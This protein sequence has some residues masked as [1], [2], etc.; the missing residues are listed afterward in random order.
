MRRDGLVD[1]FVHRKVGIHDQTLHLLAIRIAE[2]L[3]KKAAPGGTAGEP[4]NLYA[5]Q[6]GVALFFSM[7]YRVSGEDFFRRLALSLLE[8]YRARLLQRDGAE[9]LVRE[10]GLGAAAGLGAALYMLE[11][12]A[13]LC[14]EA[15]LMADAGRLVER[16]TPAL[17]EL[18]A[19][20]DLL[21]GSG[22][23][24]LPLLSLHD[25]MQTEEPL[26]K[27]V[28]AG[29]FL[30][31]RRTAAENGLR[32]WR[33][34]R[35]SVMDGKLLTGFS[36][37]AAG[38]A[39]ALFKLYERSGDE[40]FLAA[41]MEAVLYEQSQFSR[42]AGNWPDYR[43]TGEAVFQYANNWCHGAPGIVLARIGGLAVADNPAIREEIEI[44]LKTLTADEQ[45]ATYD[46]LCC[47][48]AGRLD[49]LMAAAQKLRRPHLYGRARRRLEKML[50]RS[51]ERGKFLLPPAESRY[52]I[53]LFCGMAGIGY[54]LLR[55]LYPDKV[56]CV[57]LFE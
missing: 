22:G 53:G 17:L 28:M 42:E 44:G 35:I 57:L 2:R 51:V 54:V 25:G 46:H 49:V 13:R 5:G 39:Y 9:R 12:V 29:R 23:L 8:P 18:D 11:K 20:F 41:G 7:Y 34:R 26:A 55:F 14:G 50:W 1:G 27:A 47:G 45:E 24:I 4:G 19:D 48:E 33:G 36:H 6:G 15:E 52:K 16:L 43:Q 21:Y 32:A 38:I 31:E 37:G 3:A 40:A 56:P 10:Q 30:V